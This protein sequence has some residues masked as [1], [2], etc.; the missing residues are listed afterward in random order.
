MYYTLILIVISLLWSLV[1]AQLFKV[2]RV[3]IKNIKINNTIKIIFISD[4]HYGDHYKR[5]RLKRIIDKINELNPNMVLIGGDYLDFEKNSKLNRPLLD[6]VF[7]EL[8]NLKSTHGVFSVLGNH[9]YLL[10][11]NMNLLLKDM[12]DSNIILLKNNTQELNIQGDR[13]LIHGV[14]DYIEGNIDIKRLTTDNRCLNILI[15]HNPD[16]YEGVSVDYDIGLS[17]HTHGGQITLFGL[18]APIT[19]S[20]YGQKYVNTIN[21]RGKSIVITSK[22]LGCSMLPIRFFAMPE[23]IELIIENGE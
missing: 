20:K 9:E 11:E 1:E 3:V 2:K 13:V 22:G 19:N 18:Y 23:I 5:F 7:S 17:G 15:S 21:K 4:L 6:E 12:K 14:D 10:G 16:F 8:Y